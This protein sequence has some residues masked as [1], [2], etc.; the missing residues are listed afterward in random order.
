MEN[1]KE[2]W[3][4]KKYVSPMYKSNDGET[5]NATYPIM[6]GVYDYIWEMTDGVE[7][8]DIPDEIWLGHVN[9]YLE[10]W[11]MGSGIKYLGIKNN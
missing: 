7:T 1:I 3:W 5:H 11:C 6:D 2:L 9:D 4:S 8:E 10:N